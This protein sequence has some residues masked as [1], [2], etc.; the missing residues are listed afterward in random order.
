MSFTTTLNQQCDNHD[1][2][3]NVETYGFK[4][5]FGGVVLHHDG[6]EILHPVGYD[7]KTHI[8]IIWNWDNYNKTLIT[9]IEAMEEWSLG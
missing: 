9:I 7:L 8:L 5:V 3:G 2:M 1:R 6:L 4:N